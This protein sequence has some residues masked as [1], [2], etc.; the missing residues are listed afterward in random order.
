MRPHTILACFGLLVVTFT[1]CNGLGHN[2]SFLLQYKKDVRCFYAQRGSSSDNLKAISVSGKPA[3]IDTDDCKERRVIKTVETSEERLKD[4]HVYLPYIFTTNL[5]YSI[6]NH[7]DFRSAGEPIRQGDPLS[8]IINKVHLADNGEYLPWI[9]TGEI[10]VVVTVD[11]SSDKKPQ[12]VIVAYETGLP[13]NVNLPISDLLAYH[14][15][16][17]KSQSLRIE[18]TVFDLDRKEN[19]SYRKMLQRAAILGSVYPPAAGALSLAN[20]IGTQL[21]DENQDDI[22]VSFKF[23]L[24]PWKAGQP[25]LISDEIGVPKLISAGHY[26]IVSW[27]KPIEREMLKRIHADWDL[28]VF[29]VKRDPALRLPDIYNEKDCPGPASASALNHEMNHLTSSKNEPS[30]DPNSSRMIRRWPIDPDCDNR[31]VKT[32]VHA[33]YIVLTVDSRPLPAAQQLLARVNLLNQT[34]SGLT[35]TDQLEQDS[36]KFLVDGF[37]DMKSLAVRAAAENFFFKGK[38]DPQTLTHLFEAY[39][40]TKPHDQRALLHLIRTQLPP[41][42]LDKYS[43]AIRSG[44]RHDEDLTFYKEFYNRVKHCLTYDRGLGRYALL[45]EDDSTAKCGSFPE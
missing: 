33:N 17:Y 28:S 27:P 12:H 34:L 3:G 20:E 42:I 26:L 41:N 16:S 22:I 24:Y 6:T 39:E 31:F 45:N 1:G 30:I 9:D 43:K 11:D 29:E 35:Y 13:D 18:V 2:Y 21:I 10:A 38:D 44:H 14:T 7:Y 40:N 8:I 4:A 23:L 15:D 37:D 19:E 5:P 36:T 25:K 32:P